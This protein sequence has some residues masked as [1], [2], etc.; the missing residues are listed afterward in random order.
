ML[1]AEDYYFLNTITTPALDIFIRRP[2]VSSS[3]SCHFMYIFLLQWM[4]G[5]YVYLVKTPRIGAVSECSQ[6]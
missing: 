3:L 6:Q 4:L 5:I 2:N 1:D